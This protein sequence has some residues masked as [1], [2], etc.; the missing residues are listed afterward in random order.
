MTPGMTAVFI[1]AFG[2]AFGLLPLVWPEPAPSAGPLFIAL[3]VGLAAAQLYG[4][5]Q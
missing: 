2:A 1:L 3:V 4:V 5:F